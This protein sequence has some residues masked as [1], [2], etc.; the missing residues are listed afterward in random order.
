MSRKQFSHFRSQWPWPWP[1]DLKFYALVALVRRCISTKLEVST[2]RLLRF[3]KIEGTGWTDRHSDGRGRGR[4]QRIM[5]PEFLVTATK[6]GSI[7][8][9]LQID[10]FAVETYS[11]YAPWCQ[12]FRADS[13]TL[14]W[15]FLTCH[16]QSTTAC[17]LSCIRRYKQMNHQLA[18]TV[19]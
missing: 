19:Q 11:T 18:A 16:I 6:H 2:V 9:N 7:A 5:R 17:S 14:T 8:T 15:E 12:W 3:Q 1:F 4:D 10:K 13:C